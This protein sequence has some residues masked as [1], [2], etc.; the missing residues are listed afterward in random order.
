MSLNDFTLTITQNFTGADDGTFDKLPTTT[1]AQGTGGTIKVT[2]K[3]GIA[4]KVEVGDAGSGYKKDD[5]IT[6]AQTSV[7]NAST[8]LIVTL[9]EKTTQPTAK[10]EGDWWYNL[11]IGWKTLI[12][13]IILIILGCLWQFVFLPWMFPDK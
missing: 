5:T 13:A 12:I 1:S 9:N 6:I 10:E 2:V 3:N 4:T 11:G 8:E 7:A